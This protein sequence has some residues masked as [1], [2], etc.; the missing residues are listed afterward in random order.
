MTRFA[1][2]QPQFS[3][4]NGVPL[5][6]GK[7]HFYTV[8]TNTNKDTYSDDA[9]STPNAN[10]VILDGDGRPTTDINIDGVYKV[11]LRD[12]N[13]VVIWEKDPVGGVGSTIAFSDWVNNVSY[14]T[15]DLV[16]GSNGRYYRSLT[17]ANLGNDPSTPSVF[18][19]EIY[20]LPSS[21]VRTHFYRNR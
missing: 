20:L 8:G 14:S 18:W 21:A 3:D 1:N 2:P 5:A 12:K 19:E 7:L 17:N 4:K 10:P 13:N 9:L 15:G 6:G 11:V 16:T